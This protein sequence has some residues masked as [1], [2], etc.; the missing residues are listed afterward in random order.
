MGNQSRQD[1][2]QLIRDWGKLLLEHE[3]S[4]RDAQNEVLLKVEDEHIAYAITA[5]TALAMRGGLIQV[6]NQTNI[7]TA[8][9]AITGGTSHGSI[10]GNVQQNINQ[11]IKSVLESL[12]KLRHELLNSTA[13]N[14][15]QKEDSALAIADLE[16]EI[17]KPDAERKGS[18]IRTALGVLTSTASLVE[19]AQKLY[20]AIA[21]HLQTLGHLL[22]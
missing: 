3:I 9:V 17:Q 12:G 21:P 11:D 1:V 13:L 7:G 2:T 16:T 22:K 4:V 20:E 6:T 15:E 18:R 5:M 10:T 19:G 8:G 14:D